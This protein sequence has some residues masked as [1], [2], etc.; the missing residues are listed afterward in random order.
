MLAETACSAPTPTVRHA[1]RSPISSDTMAGLMVLGAAVVF[2]IRDADEVIA[3][4]DNGHGPLS[5][6]PLWVQAALFL[7][8]IRSRHVRSPYD[9]NAA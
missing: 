4:Y 5:E 7:V 3:F 1:R 9:P 8:L 6:L 2:N